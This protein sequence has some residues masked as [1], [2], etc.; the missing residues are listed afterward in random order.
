MKKLCLA[1]ILA[2]LLLMA[3]CASVPKCFVNVDSL[4]A[5]GTDDKKNFILLPGNKDTSLSD[6]QFR[7]YEAY[8][9]RALI[10]RGFVPAESIETANLAIFV[11]YGI[12]DP[13]QHQYSY[14]VPVWGQTG[15][16]SS[17]TQG[18]LSTY[19]NYGT[20][21]G[22]TTYNPTYGI[23]GYSSHVGT[24]TTYFRFLV[25]DAIDLSEYRKSKKEVQL[26]KTTVTSAGRSGDLRRV[27]PIMVT[28]SKPHI[29]TN[30]GQQIKIEI[31][32][33]DPN[34][35]EIKNQVPMSPKK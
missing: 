8:I 2:L 18:M 31:Y 25:L 9:N 24:Y 26:W 32:E 11:V 23:K 7:E 1:S 17:T 19:G 22:T 14:S 34:I 13:Q 3:G 4:Q 6:L 28:A 20:Y 29:A 5:P 27:F 30:S 12:G 21:S 10:S 33:N 35:L 16:S 15:V